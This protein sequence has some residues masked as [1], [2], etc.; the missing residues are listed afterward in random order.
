MNKYRAAY[1]IVVLIT[2][3]LMF[4]FGNIYFLV[5]FI[6][7]ILLFF[8]LGLLLKID[9]AGM[10]LSCR[11]RISCVVGQDAGLYVSL[12]NERKKMLA[13]GVLELTAEFEN[14]LFGVTQKQQFSIALGENE[15]NVELPF[16]SEWCGEIHVSL[17]EVYC[18]DVFGVFR[19]P[20]SAPGQRLLTVYPERFSFQMVNRKMFQGRLDGEQYDLGRKG[21]DVSE[22]FELREYQP[23]DDIR[24]I[25]WKLSSK[26]DT[27]IIREGSDSSHYDVVILFDAGFKTAEMQWG[28]KALMAAIQFSIT[29]CEKLV[30]MGI[31]HDIAIPANG[32][33]FTEQI[34][35]QADFVRMEATW[36]GLPIQEQSG[37]GLRYFLT[38]KMQ[39]KYTKLIYITVGECPESILQMAES[40]DITAIDIQEMGEEV[41]L[42]RKGLCEIIELP[43]GVINKN[44]HNIFV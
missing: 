10:V 7:E 31:P 44:I 32:Q 29:L 36:M 37:G 28:K 25:H 19:I 6:V 26:L 33:L 8:L 18:C 27:M 39:E 38:E 11:T 41:G 23:G 30:E 20:L 34:A 13:A 22:V 42:S 24:S 12:K 40:V 2:A 14:L 4:Y 15:L 17:T 43:L 9:T 16:V 21:H 3:G 5:L 35:E 1:G